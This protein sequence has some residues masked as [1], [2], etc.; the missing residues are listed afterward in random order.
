VRKTPHF[1]PFIHKNYHFTKTGSGQTYGKLKKESAD[2]GQSYTQQPVCVGGV[3]VSIASF[4]YPGRECACVCACV[5][6]SVRVEGVLYVVHNVPL[7]LGGFVVV[8]GDAHACQVPG[9]VHDGV[10][11]CNDT[12]GIAGSVRLRQFSGQN[13]TRF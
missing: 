12:H 11:L 2:G 1:A 3:C 5:A 7:K 13:A 4:M 6:P 9:L 10:H 8:G